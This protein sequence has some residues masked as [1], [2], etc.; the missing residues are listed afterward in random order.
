MIDQ[1]QKSV[2]VLA[3]LAGEILMKSGSEIYR[4]EETVIKI[5]KAFNVPYAEVFATTTGIFLSIDSGDDAYPYTLI[6]R[7][8][9]GSIDLQKISEINSFSRQLADSPTEVE[10]DLALLKSV[11][12]KPVYR[13]P[14][15]LL[16]AAMIASFFTLMLGGTW[17]DFG[18]AL[19]S[20]IATYGF[21]L[22]LDRFRLNAYIRYFFACALTALFSLLAVTY[23]PA[24]N[25]NALIVGG[26]MLFLPGLALT[27]AVRDSLAGDLLAGSARMLEAG[28]IAAT[29]AAGVGTSLSLWVMLGGAL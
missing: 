19:L 26:L 25:I 1:K 29:T 15:Q 8:K 13:L 4:V 24:E 10:E 7:I 6:K 16:G 18:C 28:L 17:A 2:L 9:G 3:L 21:A 11:R 20:G 22:V 23:G 14:V 27:N 12:K 5:C